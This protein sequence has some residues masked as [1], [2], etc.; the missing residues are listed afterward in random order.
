MPAPACSHPAQL[1]RA[2]RLNLLDPLRE[3]YVLGNKLILAFGLYGKS[4]Q[5]CDSTC[6]M[7]VCQFKGGALLS[8]SSQNPITFTRSQTP[9]R[10]ARSIRLTT[11]GMPPS[12]SALREPTSVT[13]QCEVVEQSQSSVRRP[14]QIARYSFRG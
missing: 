5:L 14:R 2:N 3:I 13:C 11:R 12:T 10:T 7:P 9:L 8:T 4:L 6:S 1:F